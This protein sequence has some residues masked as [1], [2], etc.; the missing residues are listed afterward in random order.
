MTWNIASV[1]P[2]L[3]C[4]RSVCALRSDPRPSQIAISE[5]PSC[6]AGGFFLG[7][8]IR[9]YATESYMIDRKSTRLKSSH[10]CALLKQVSAR[11]NNVTHVYYPP[12]S[13]HYFYD[14]IPCITLPQ[15]YI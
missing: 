12:L 9:S 13:N 5:K 11:K 6:S 8:T 4:F 3:R 1:K 10:L 15:P 2:R 7:Y 14:E